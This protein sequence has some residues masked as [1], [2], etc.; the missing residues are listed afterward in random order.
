MSAT[1]ELRRLL[2]ER[3]V[4]WRG[5]DRDVRTWFDVN[6]I[7]WFVLEHSNGNLSADAVFLTPAQ[8]IAA[9]LGITGKVSAK[10]TERDS[11][12]TAVRQDGVGTCYPVPIYSFDGEFTEYE[13]DA[14]S[15]CGTEWEGDTP[16][17][18]P[19]CGRKVVDE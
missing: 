11:D 8:A 3:G 2:D 4:E 13:C 7:P 17:F 10:V 1:D 18:C 14:C 19:Y 6:G 9:T 16:N 5:A 12:A 15:E